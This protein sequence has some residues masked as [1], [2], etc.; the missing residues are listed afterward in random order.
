M[1]HLVFHVC[2]SET[3]LSPESMQ[4]C[5]PKSE[6]PKCCQSENKIDIEPSFCCENI[7]WYYF[8]PKFNDGFKKQINIPVQPS[9]ILGIHHNVESLKSI[10]ST[11]LSSFNKTQH[12]PPIQSPILEE[13]CVW[14]I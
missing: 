7:Q 9:I 1:F 6:V 4:C 3:S 2:T 10:C 8:T 12:P 5:H 13:I 11:D 14:I